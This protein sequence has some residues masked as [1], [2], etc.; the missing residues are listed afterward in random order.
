[1]LTTL[2]AL[3]LIRPPHAVELVPTDDVWVYPHAS[4]QRDAYLRVWGAE[5]ASVAATADGAQSFSYAYL[6]FD[7]TG[8]SD[9]RVAEATLTLFHV[10]DPAF[11]AGASKQSPI[12]VRPVS[13]KF[14]EK[15]WDYDAGIAASPPA[16]K[17]SIFGSTAVIKW[18][19]SLPFSV[20]ID[21]T[22]GKGGFLK[23]L[24]EAKKANA[25][26]LALT[27][28][29]DASTRAVYKFYSKDGEPRYRPTLRIVF[30]Q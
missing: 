13:A 7:L 22:S 21:L 6:R 16:G 2:L 14:T 12:E 9:E 1:M 5:G 28:S 3:A 4:D 25:L 30:S 24:E 20:T 19:E 8:L 17:E 23:G 26:G 15:T 10:S 18:P 11:S 27:S 29:L